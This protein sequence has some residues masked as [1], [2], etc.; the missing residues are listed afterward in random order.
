MDEETRWWNQEPGALDANVYETRFV[1]LPSDAAEVFRRSDADHVLYVV[2]QYWCDQADDEVHVE[3]LV[4][5]DAAFGL[6]ARGG[7]EEVVEVWEGDHSPWFGWQPPHFDPY[8]WFPGY[9]E[10]IPAFE[11]FCGEYGSQEADWGDNYRA[12]AFA[13]RT[14]PGRVHWVAAPAR[15]WLD[16]ARPP[17]SAHRYDTM[18][19]TLLGRPDGLGVLADYWREQGDARGAWLATLRRGP[20]N[21]KAWRRI[22]EGWVEQRDAWLGELGHFVPRSGIDLG[23]R[24]LTDLGLYV[25]EGADPPVDHP[26][27]A[28]VRQLRFLPTSRG[29]LSDGVR[30]VEAIGAI[31]PSVA[32]LA[33]ALSSPMEARFLELEGVTVEGL[34]GLDWSA[35]PRLTTLRLS[36]DALSPGLLGVLDRV[37]APEVALEI[38]PVQ[39]DPRDVFGSSDQR[40][41]AADVYAEAVEAWLDHPVCRD[42]TRTVS[43]WQQDPTT[44]RATGFAVARHRGALELRQT[45]LSV[46]A[47]LEAYRAA[48]E[49]LGELSLALWTPAS[50]P[51][52]PLPRPT[53]A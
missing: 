26:V 21:P 16:A 13:S 24:F 15:P 20:E 30:H 2:G 31:A 3:Q 50:H 40:Q 32:A 42:G 34:Q 5:D 23:P 29:F 37:L 12:L 53:G 1:T 17:Q 39:T 9:G 19:A 14:S 46:A 49:R 44:Q 48:T 47:D 38:A 7:L 36:G 25:P 52:G 28:A 33:E 18:A 41:R 10:L 43:I 22:L 35:W 4:S 45:S 8:H 11:A 27:F 6:A 51:A